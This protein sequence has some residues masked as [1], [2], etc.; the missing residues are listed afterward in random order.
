MMVADVRHQVAPWATAPHG[1]HG[2]YRVGGYLII[3]LETAPA[4]VA[5]SGLVREWATCLVEVCRYDEMGLRARLAESLMSSGPLALAL[6][7]LQ[8][9]LFLPTAERRWTPLAELMDTG[10]E[11]LR[12]AVAVRLPLHGDAC[13]SAFVPAPAVRGA[14]TTLQAVA[15][16]IR[17]DRE[18][19]LVRAVG[20]AL[21]PRYGSIV[22]TALAETVL[23]GQAV[24]VAAIAQAAQAVQAQTQEMLGPGPLSAAFAV[25][26]TAHLVRKALDRAA[27]RALAML[28]T[29]R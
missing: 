6:A 14:A 7:A 29:Q 5:H 21:L 8:A 17:L 25:P 2:I 9:E 15:A 26:V 18:H 27:A 13:G 4:D 24:T 10:F 1:A 28:S 12:T 23:R 19:R 22:A 20:L 16:S 3:G 11:H